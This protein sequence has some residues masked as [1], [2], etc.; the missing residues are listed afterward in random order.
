MPQHSPLLTLIVAGLVA[1]FLLGLLARRLG[2]PPLVGYLV[3]GVLVG[4]HTPG[5][6][7]DESLAHQLA[8]IGVILLMFGVGLHLAPR[9]LAAVRGVAVPGALAQIAVATL[10]GCGI[11]LA[12]GWTVGA[13]L[14]FGLALSVASTVVLLRALEE[15]GLV[16]TP[17][18]RVVIGWLVVEDLAMVAALVAIPALAAA[19][20]TGGGWGPVVAALGWRL[21]EVTLFAAGM[22]VFGRRVVPWLL[23]RAAATDS[24]ELF[25]LAVLATAMGIAFGAAALFG[26]SFA[27]GAFF[28][29]MVLAESEL[30]HRAGADILP[31]QDA[32]AV[33]FF[34][35]VGML[36]DPGVLLRQ[37]LGA[38]ASVGVVI[39]GKSL[40]ALL[41]ARLLGEP[42]GL[43][44]TVAA[45]LGQVGEF[46]F[47]LAALGVSLG[48][49]PPAGQD[50]ILAASL[51][52][53]ALN[54]LLF[55]LAGRLEPALPLRPRLARLLGRG[56]A[57]E[58]PAP[59]RH[60]V[61][62]SWSG[63]VVVVGHGRVGALVA[64][65]L[66]GRGIRVAVVETDAAIVARLEQ[67]GVPVA[68]GEIVNPAV[69]AS[70][71]LGRAR[72]V[73]LAIPDSYQTRRAQDVLHA[74]N[75]RA[76]VVARTHGETAFAS[77]EESG[78][79]LAVNDERELA[80]RIGQRA[81]EAMGVPAE[82]A[83][84]ATGMLPR[85]PA[86]ERAG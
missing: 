31:L 12:L 53:I 28:A 36:F 22:L 81:L 69:A 67:A 35:S 33:L 65:L 11:G 9:D 42:P 27:L 34:V 8:E 14:V 75:P 58:P 4:P 63:H 40:A 57:A 59:S 19:A 13:G 2:L 80:L 26:V 5:F 70:V 48:L 3:A 52:S 17:R 38:L 29:G 77:P 20:E 24:H 82:E 83:R 62:E 21:A 47:I 43:G 32:F 46:S 56:G 39:L 55:A 64:R 74:A 16:R 44:L 49:L 71:G 84:L 50:L 68:L 45:G 86:I 79:R 54:P 7:A 61:P 15:R 6:V 78:A 60:A 23:A 18:G 10:L 66:R 72:L 30:S 85:A 51:I 1:A 25:T 41:I 76:A 73:V 37:P